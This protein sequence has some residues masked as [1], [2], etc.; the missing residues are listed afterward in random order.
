M[1][2]ATGS[3]RELSRGVTTDAE[4]TPLAP[5]FFRLLQLDFL[6][7]LPS[8]GGRNKS[9]RPA[10]GAVPVP[11]LARLPAC[12]RSPL[13][14]QD[15]CLIL[16]SVESQS[17]LPQYFLL[18]VRGWL[19]LCGCHGRQ[20]ADT[21]SNCTQNHP[22]YAPDAAPPLFPAK[23]WLVYESYINPA[24]CRGT[25]LLENCMLDDLPL[26]LQA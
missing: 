16:Q 7:V 22:N 25:S 4:P 19:A 2:R 18:K 26:P 12:A 10:H 5:R 20:P 11:R 8:V 24:Q 23:E 17:T 15:Y 3:T 13:R 1:V 21:G 14:L 9:E 6:H